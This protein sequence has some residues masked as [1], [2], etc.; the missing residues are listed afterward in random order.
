M[1]DIL[2]GILSI[3]F[4][5]TYF[6]PTFNSL[7]LRTE[8]LDKYLGVYSST[9]IPLKITITKNSTTLTSQ[10]TGQSPF[11]LEATEKDKF[12]FHPAGIIMEFN[13]DKNELTL[14]QGGETV[15]FTKEK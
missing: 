5:K 6:V 14:K 4:N 2:I 12:T 11:P 1:N 7:S 8:D 15:L 13:P 3:Y 10:A 9:Q